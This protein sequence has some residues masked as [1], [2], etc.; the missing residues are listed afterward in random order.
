MD[1][2]RVIAKLEPGGAQLSALRLSRALLAYGIRTL[3]LLAAEATPQGVDLARRYGVP[4]EVFSTPA[5]LQWKASPAFASWLAPRLA[6]ADLVHAHMF[7]GWWAAAQVLGATTPLVASEHN[8]MSWPFG[9]EGAAAAEEA[10]A[11]AVARVD[12]FMAHGPAAQAFA[13]RIGV[14]PE[15][16]HEG[17]SPVEGFDAR[18]LRALR[19]PRIT[20]TGRLCP[21]KGPDVLVDALALLRRAPAAYLV[22]DGP[23]RQPLRARVRRAGLSRRVALPGWSYRPERY[24]AGS[25]VHVV[26]SREEAWSQSAVIALGLGVPVI[27]TAVDGLAHTLG[28]GRG[29]LVPPDDP[30]AL[31]AALARVLAGDRPDPAGGTAYA[32]QF[33]P[34]VVA[35]HY[36]HHYRRLAQQVEV[37]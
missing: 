14:A 15:R 31:A 22:G 24:V 29:V 2:V 32:A 6:G 1:V 28:D 16:L 19:S 10:A 27:G 36:A 35:Q 4:T 12:A 20:F 13:R 34:P 18:P 26:P 33:T 17:R 9:I 8:E 3:R 5:G 23:L 37:A 11:E 7:G 30:A 25:A 21:D